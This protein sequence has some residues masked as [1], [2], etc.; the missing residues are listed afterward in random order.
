MKK[1][2]KVKT[3]IVYRNHPIP[4]DE[5]Y[6]EKEQKAALTKDIED[7]QAKKA[8]APKG[9]K[10]FLQKAQ[11]NKQINDKSKYIK[12]KEGARNLKEETIKLGHQIE[13]EKKKNELQELRKKNEVNFN[14]FGLAP[15]T[16]RK[17]LK[18]EDLF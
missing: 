6:F 8:L 17:E 16:P 10:G 15:R 11:I 18:F 7:L 13:Y 3:K 1:K 5:A 14:S 4:K 2:N 9:F 12:S